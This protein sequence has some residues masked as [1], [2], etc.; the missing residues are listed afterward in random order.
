MLALKLSYQPLKFSVAVISTAVRFLNTFGDLV[1][2]FLIYKITI[3]LC[4]SQEHC[5]DQHIRHCENLGTAVG[6]AMQALQNDVIAV[7]CEFISTL[8]LIYM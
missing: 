2:L 8:T 7:T 6:R 5:E 3:F 4:I 1:L